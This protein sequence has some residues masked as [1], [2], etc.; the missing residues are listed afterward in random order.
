MDRGARGG[1]GLSEFEIIKVRVETDEREL[2]SMHRYD[3]AE[4][5]FSQAHLIIRVRRDPYSYLL[6]YSN[7]IYAIIL[8]YCLPLNMQANVPSASSIQCS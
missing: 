3:N 6:R 8:F 5:S 2:S 1:I 4:G 7:W